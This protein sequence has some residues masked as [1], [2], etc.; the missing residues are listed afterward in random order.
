MSN[1]DPY[2]KWLGIPKDRRPPTYYDILGLAPGESDDDAVRSAAQQRRHFVSLKQGEGHDGEVR[3]ILVQIDE[4]V[5][6]LLVPTFKHEYDR[7]LKIGESKAGKTRTHPLP[8]WFEYLQVRIY[9][10]GS[11][12][13]STLIAIVLV[14]GT[15]FALMLWFSFQMPWGKPASVNSKIAVENRSSDTDI[16]TAVDATAKAA[17]PSESSEDSWS[18]LVPSWLGGKNQFYSFEDISAATGLTQGE[19]VEHIQVSAIPNPSAKKTDQGKP[20]WEA[21]K[22]EPWIAEF[23]G[24]SKDDLIRFVR[25]SSGGGTLLQTPQMRQGG[26]DLLSKIELPRHVLSPTWKRIGSDFICESTETRNAILQIPYDAPAEYTIE[27]KVRTLAANLTGALLIGLANDEVGFGAHLKGDRAQSWLFDYRQQE[28]SPENGMHK[29]RMPAKFFQSDSPVVVSCT[30]GKDFVRISENGTIKLEWKGDFATLS[31]KKCWAVQ[32]LPNQ[33]AMF[34]CSWGSFEFSEIKIHPEPSFGKL[35]QISPSMDLRS[36]PSSKGVRPSTRPNEK[37]NLPSR[38]PSQNPIDAV[39]N[40]AFGVPILEAR[41]EDWDL[42]TS[43]Y[44]RT[45]GNRF[46][47]GMGSGSNGFGVAAAGW[48]VKDVSSVV[49]E[50]ELFGIFETKDNNT[51]AGLV[52]DFQS[53]GRFTKR[54][55]ITP[56]NVAKNRSATYPNW[57]S[58]SV[59]H[60]IRKI[61]EASTYGVD[62][63]EFAPP[64]WMGEAFISLLL[65]NTG[66]NTGVR[67]TITMI[68]SSDSGS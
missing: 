64:R 32:G 15:A 40:T 62:L 49:V 48:R 6:C 41:T 68:P 55:A 50:T 19:I 7:R 27:F 37:A 66:A 42:S 11:G 16:E 54:V 3:R 46:E 60:E 44:V 57:G 63:D 20:L 26:I 18:S 22:I 2:L 21:A 45:V 51:F 23:P 61:P 28:A 35:S 8:T 25:R 9:G 24:K 1:F 56:M 59:P 29:Q 67:G 30:V 17:E 4:S 13:V 12:I 52:I 14:I 31:R 36:D 5:A 33:R 38:V 10:D 43:D 53:N 58:G 34:L 65:E 47:L 39:G